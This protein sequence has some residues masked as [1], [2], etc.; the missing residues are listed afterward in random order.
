MASFPHPRSYRLRKGYK[1]GSALRHLNRGRVDVQPMQ[2]P[3]RIGSRAIRVVGPCRV[4]DPT[5][6]RQTRVVAVVNSV[7]RI[8]R[9]RR[10]RADLGVRG[11]RLPAVRAECPPELSIVVRHAVSVAGS[12]GAKVLTGVIP[13][14]SK[15]PAG[16]IERDLR[17][18][19]AVLRVVVVHSRWTA[20]RGT[21][22]I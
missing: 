16:R 11:K 9:V 1:K 12:T 18:E 5:V 3:I 17:Q 10:A 6:E 22:V 15:V 13:H 2:S 21:V 19:L 4:G 8:A 7:S 20:P 14:H